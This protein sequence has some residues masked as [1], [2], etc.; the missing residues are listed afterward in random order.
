LARSVAILVVFKDIALLN[1]SDDNVVKRSLGLP[2][3]ASRHVRHRLR[4]RQCRAGSG[5]AGWHIGG[6]YEA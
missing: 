1:S 4:L 5:K 6:L 2:A 3:I